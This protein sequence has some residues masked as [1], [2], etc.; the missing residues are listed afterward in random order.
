MKEI[1]LKG[2]MVAVVDDGDFERVSTFVW[3]PLV[4]R[5]G[6]F[7]AR[8]TVR[9]EGGRQK[10]ILLHRV[11]MNAPEDMKVDHKDGNGLNN[12]RE[13]LRLATH[14]QNHCNRD[15]QANNKTGFKG[16]MFDKRRGKYFA[17]VQTKGR[18][19]F[20]GYFDNPAD[21]ARAYDKK[22]KE[23]FGEFAKLNFPE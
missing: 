2:N 16:V 9:L 21:A 23:I 1:P 13:N 4:G 12:T 10:T 3:S 19:H 15:K 20:A 8:R 5:N 7:Y 14:S 11:I 22:A 6:N 17:N 18:G